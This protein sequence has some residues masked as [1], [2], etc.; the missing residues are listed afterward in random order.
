MDDRLAGREGNGGEGG[1]LM[2]IPIK[3]T[4]THQPGGL[5]LGS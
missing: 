1:N 3:F 5:S 2:R 4:F